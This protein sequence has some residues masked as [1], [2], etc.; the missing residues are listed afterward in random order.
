MCVG[1]IT[2]AIATI[3]NVWAINKIS[4]HRNI[5]IKN[6]HRK[7]KKILELF[8]DKL[9]SFYSQVYTRSLFPVNCHT[10]YIY[11]GKVSPMNALTIEF[12]CVEVVD[13]VLK[14]SNS[15]FI[16]RYFASA[17]F[18]PQSL[19]TSTLWNEQEYALAMFV[20]YKMHFNNT[21]F[22]YY[23]HCL[24]ALIS[25]LLIKLLSVIYVYRQRSF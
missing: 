1:A 14:N 3:H 2:A 23:W 18:F 19:S 9:C 7:K 15:N 21:K 20:L 24:M 12:I 6:V 10:E 4:F 11:M 22:Q 5:L 16:Y 8:I 25:I 13:K 17:Q